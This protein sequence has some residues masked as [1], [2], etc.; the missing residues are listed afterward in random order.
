LTIRGDIVERN[1]PDEDVVLVEHRHAPHSDVSHAFRDIFDRV[2]LQTEMDVLG[3][4]VIDGTRVNR[5]SRGNR[6]NHDVAIGDQ[7][8]QAVA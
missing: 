5:F 3:H 4:H 6:A 7:A 8:D 2:I 1:D